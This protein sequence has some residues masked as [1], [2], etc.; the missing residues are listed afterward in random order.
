MFKSWKSVALGVAAVIAAA[1]VSSCGGEQKTAS[2]VKV[3][4]D[5]IYPVECE[6]TITYWT[7][8][9]AQLEG[10]VENFGETPLAKALEEKTG[11]KVE[12]IHP[13]A[14]NAGEQVNVLMASNDLPDIVSYNWSAYAGGPQKA[15]EEGYIYDLT[16]AVKKWAPALSKYMSEHEGIDKRIKTDEGQIYEFPPIRGV[17]WITACQGLVMRQDWLDKL[18]MD[19]PKSVDELEKV[20]EGFKTISNRAPLVLRQDQYGFMLWAYG[21]MPD[22]YVDGETV[23]YGPLQPEYKQGLQKL[24]EWYNKGLLDNNFV[25]A[26]SKYTQARMLNGDAGAF[27]GYVVSGMGA[28]LDAKPSDQPSFDLVAVRQPTLDGGKPEYSYTEDIIYQPRCVAISKNCKNLELAVRYL[29]FGYTDEGHN[30]YNFG[31]EGESYTMVDGKPIFTDLIKNNPDGLSFVQAADL[32]TKGAYAGMFV[33][34]PD[35]VRQSLTYP[36]KQQHAYDVW[37]DSNAAD[38]IMPPVSLSAEEQ[39]EVADVIS[40]INTYVSEKYVAYITGKESFDTYDD[41]VAQLKSFGID[42]VLEYR[43]NALD[44]YNKR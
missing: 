13:Q 32:Y 17:Q 19:A 34:D 28:L 14:G 36:E 39:G 1:A 4:G 26:D 24:N 30:M 37:G 33:H 44:R 2:T 6:D 22:F 23:K 16:D 38:H 10:L 15:I 42:K 41:F 25:S 29:D 3:N 20:L 31:I 11:I 43:Q 9:D 18:G 27:M 8:F 7:E 35:Y 40:N 5:A 12:Y 21:T